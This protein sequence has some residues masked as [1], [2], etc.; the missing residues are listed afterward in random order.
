ML[1]YLS[2]SGESLTRTNLPSIGFCDE[3]VRLLDDFLAAIRHMNELHTQQTRA[4]IEG[5]PEF[6]RFDLLLNLAQQRKDRAKY[7]WM[8]HVESHGCCG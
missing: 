3:N 8:S 5:D 2:N 1:A 7:A 6:P 4:V